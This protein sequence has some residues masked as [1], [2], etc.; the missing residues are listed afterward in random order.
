[1]SEPTKPEVGRPENNREPTTS[2]PEPLRR[3]AN[4]RRA[5]SAADLARRDAGWLNTAR[6]LTFRTRTQN[7][8]VGDSGQPRLVTAARNGRFRHVTTPPEFAKFVDRLVAFEG[9]EVIETT[10]AEWRR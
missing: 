4:R 5:C 2:V 7:R 3:A 9:A 6:S 10:D 8:S 1:M